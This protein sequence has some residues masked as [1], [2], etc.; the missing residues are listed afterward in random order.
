MAR[1]LLFDI[2]H[3]L[4]YTGG[5]G[6]KAM[7]LALQD[8]FGIVDGFAKVEFSGRTDVAIFRDAVRLHRIDGDF[9]WLLARFKEVYV[10]HLARTLTETSGSLM[11]GIEPLLEELSPRNDILLGLATGNFRGGAELK[12]RYYGIW[13]YFRGGA[14]A[15]DAEDR[16]EIVGLAARRVLGDRAGAHQVLVVGDTPLDIAAAK[17]K[18]AMAVAV[19][20]GKYSQ[21]DLSKS[22]ADIVLA[23]LSDWRA[24]IAALGG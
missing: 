24:A 8:L 21:D 18:G 17:A 16:A 9:P 6:T 4:L 10:R 20:T 15:D 19:A 12:L 22:G 13:H 3:T 1:V 14:F 7:N 11:P 2:D 5:A 23:D